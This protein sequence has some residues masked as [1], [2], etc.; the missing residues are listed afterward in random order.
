M[1]NRQQSKKTFLIFSSC[2]ARYASLP[3]IQP[4]K[5]R[6]RSKNKTQIRDLAYKTNAGPEPLVELRVE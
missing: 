3:G 4:D 6:V 1:N 5:T 2:K